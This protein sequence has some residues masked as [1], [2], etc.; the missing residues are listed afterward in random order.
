MS[1]GTGG[2][3]GL[4]NPAGGEICGG[5]GMKGAGAGASGSAGAGAGTG[6][7]TTGGTGAGAGGG[8]SVVLLAWAALDAGFSLTAAGLR[9]MVVVGA[10]R[11]GSGVG[12]GT[13]RH[14]PALLSQISFAIVHLHWSFSPQPSPTGAPQRLPHLLGVQ[15]QLLVLHM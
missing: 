10:K 1:A 7:I 12:P 9:A 14:W 13:R 2:G 15:T 11:L 4:V 5:G 6:A 3:G 8:T